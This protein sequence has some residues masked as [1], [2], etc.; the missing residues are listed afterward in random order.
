MVMAAPQAIERTLQ[1]ILILMRRCF[2]TA[3][4]RTSSAMVRTT[5]QTLQVPASLQDLRYR[6]CST[7][8][9]PLQAALVAE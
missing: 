4:H 1:R 6:A 8:S 9:Q 2:C 5:D 7:R 3:A